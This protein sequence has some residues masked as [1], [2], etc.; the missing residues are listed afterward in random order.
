MNRPFVH[1][2]TTAGALLAMAVG[3]STAA[4]GNQTYMS[5]GQGLGAGN[6]YASGSSNTGVDLTRG[7]ANHTHC[8]A[9][10]QGYGGYT[11]SPN[12]GGRWTGWST[13]GPYF[14]E[15]L[16]NGTANYSFHGAEFNP[17]QSTTDVFNYAEYYW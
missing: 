9:L 15:W 17:N 12:G 10:A 11:S 13:C 8:P 2:L 1:A 5:N 16:P 4:A 6:A 14:Q 7:Y 3:A